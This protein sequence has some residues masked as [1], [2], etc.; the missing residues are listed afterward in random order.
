MRNSKVQELRD[1]VIR[2]TSPLGNNIV[3]ALDVQL[4]DAL[5]AA[6][7][8]DEREQA[9]ARVYAIPVQDGFAS[10]VFSR[11]ILSAV[12]AIRNV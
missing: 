7:R 9:V 2:A 1:M 3:D 8:E 6:V 12:E 5:I 4:V 11:G 10:D